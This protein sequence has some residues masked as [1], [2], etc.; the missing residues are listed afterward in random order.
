LEFFISSRDKEN[1]RRKRERE[2]QNSKVKSQKKAK[3]QDAYR[4]LNAKVAKETQRPAKEETQRNYSAFPPFLFFS[5]L[6]YERGIRDERVLRV[7]YELS[8]QLNASTPQ[9]LIV[10]RN[11]NAYF[12]GV[13][14]SLTIW[15]LLLTPIYLVILI[16]I[17][18]NYRDKDLSWATPA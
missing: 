3:V 2:S 17:A 18:R 7:N 9:L 14:Q 1:K 16:S 8:Q 10:H 12:R 5:A 13:Q 4:R 6:N 15:D 11:N